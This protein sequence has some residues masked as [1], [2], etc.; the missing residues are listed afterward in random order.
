MKAMKHL[1]RVRFERINLFQANVPFLY[2]L[3]KSKGYRKGILAW[4]GLKII[5]IPVVISSDL[6]KR[7]LLHEGPRISK[8]SFSYI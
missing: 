6:R 3:K 8:S 7:S 5:S 4:N 2:A 1:Q